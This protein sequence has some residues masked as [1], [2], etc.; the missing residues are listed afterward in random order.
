MSYLEE[1]GD[2]IMENTRKASEEKRALQIDSELKSMKHRLESLT[3]T[4]DKLL[5]E[6]KASEMPEYTKVIKA[7]E[8]YMVAVNTKMTELNQSEQK[9]Q[10]D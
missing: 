10:N 1:L 4:L 6:M 5:P 8:K 9:Y 2:R 7:I 3:G